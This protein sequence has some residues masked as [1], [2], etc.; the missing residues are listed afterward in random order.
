M[1]PQRSLVNCRYKGERYYV[2]IA[3]IQEEGKGENEALRTLLFIFAGFAN[4]SS[5]FLAIAE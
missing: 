3:M 5:I 2:N 4:R 1:I